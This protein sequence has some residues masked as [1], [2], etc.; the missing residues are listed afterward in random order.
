MPTC[1]AGER[2]DDTLRHRLADTERIADRDHEIADLQRIRI[3][4]LHIGKGAVTAQPQDSEIGA[5]IAQDDIRVEL[6]L[7]GES[8]LHIGHSL[9]DVIIGD[10]E[11]GWID[12]NAG[13]ER[14][15]DLLAG[16]AAILAEEMP[17]DRIVEERIARQLFGARGID[18]DDRRLHF[19]DD[20]REGEGDFRSTG[21][22]L[23][24]ASRP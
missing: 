17:E 23:P 2:R 1:G 9:D 18:I 7:I 4:E 14:A 16:T 21:R 10:D 19:F 5:L 3:A 22:H 12:K 6:A 11:T 24:L 15:R 13:A 20:R 8:D